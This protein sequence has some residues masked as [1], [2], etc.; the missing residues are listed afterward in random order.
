MRRG[1]KIQWH[2]GICLIPHRAELFFLY[3]TSG[4]RVAA[5]DGNRKN[6]NV[7]VYKAGFTL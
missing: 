6:V 3:V 7:Q 5:A 1:K 4:A 2:G